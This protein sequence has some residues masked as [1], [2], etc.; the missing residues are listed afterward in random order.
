MKKFLL[1]VLVLAVALAFTPAA[2][3]S[4]VPFVLTVDQAT[5]T[6]T[7]TGTENLVTQV[8]TMTGWSEGPGQG[9]VDHSAVH[10]VALTPVTLGSHAIYNTDDMIWVGPGG[11]PVTGSPFSKRGFVFITQPPHADYITVIGVQL[12]PYY[13]PASISGDTEFW[14]K[15]YSGT[16]YYDVANAKVYFHPLPG[17]GIGLSTI[18]EPSP[19]FL[20]GSALLGLAF[21]VSRKAKLAARA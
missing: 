6:G 5:I 1:V 19:L 20:L 9:F 16:S 15:L 2:S 13:G 8:W 18:P 4:T 11:N 10:P 14:V 12:P 17:G 3:A 21:L 7:F